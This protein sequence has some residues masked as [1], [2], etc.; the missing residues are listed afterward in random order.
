MH[1]PCFIN[2]LYLKI[3]SLGYYQ[4]NLSKS[5]H[6]LTLLSQ[7]YVKDFSKQNIRDA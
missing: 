1:I 3:S 4:R 7:K 6:I 2:H 5:L